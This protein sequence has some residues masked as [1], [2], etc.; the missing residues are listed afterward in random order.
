MTFEEVKEF[1]AIYHHKFVVL[2]FMNNII[3][4]LMWRA[5]QHDMSKFDEQEFKTLVAL[6]AD[7]QKH[8]Y[9]TP[10]HEE[11]RKKY[12]A[13]FAIHHSKNRHHPEHFK[14]GVEEMNLMDL[15]E[16]LCDWKAASM[17]Q[18]SGGNIE[19]SLKIGAEKYNIP[20]VLLKILENTAKAC[21]M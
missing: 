7:I 14:N 1:A 4:D 19:N 11:M 15:L 3:Q 20:P 18:E 13:E 10:E 6:I 9:G 17:R 16:M 5:E 8:P 12:A 21:K 2:K